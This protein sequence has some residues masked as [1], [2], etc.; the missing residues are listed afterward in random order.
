MKKLKRIHLGNVENVLSEKALK[1]IIGGY[2]ES[3]NKNS[4]ITKCK[5][6]DCPTSAPACLRIESSFDCMCSP[7]YG[8]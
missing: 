6:D 3:N 5:A 7:H 1:L 2:D 4:C 8:K